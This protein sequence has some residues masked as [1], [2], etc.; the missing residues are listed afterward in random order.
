MRVLMVSKAVLRGPYQRKLEE[1]AR[2]GVELRVVAPPH[3]DEAGQRLSL[4]RV[5]VEGYEL[6]VEPMA[7]NGRFHLHFYPG[8]DRRLRE[9]QPDLVHLDEEP[10]NLATFHG[11][12]EAHRLGRPFLFFA[13]QNLHRRYP[14]PFSA[15]ERWVLGRAVRAIA[16]TREAEAVLRRKGF[17]RPI[18]AIPQFGVDERLFAP[19]PEPEGPFTIG[20]AG[21]LVP[22]KGMETLV[23]AA[24]GLPGEWRLR[25]VGSGAEAPRL[26]GLAGSLDVADRLSLEPPLGA[27]AMPGFY[28]HIHVLVLPS[29]TRPNWKEQFGRVLVEAM[30]S[31]RPV[32]GSESGEIPHTIGPA[33]LLFPEG[34]AEALRQQLL[35]LRS[36]AGL[37]TR[38]AQAGRERV[39]E[40]FTQAEVARRTVQAYREALG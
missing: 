13:W 22:E 34:D 1:I 12:R 17:A 29:L 4:E 33:G 32:V 39:L 15:M 7:F 24:S 27:S 6:I 35:R 11:A 10:Y 19:S 26:A 9:F 14:W 25:L 3:W 28:R 18:D 2:A 20:Y 36:D 30:S 37:R 38:L 8:L 16:G 31:G 40:R 5:H 21:R 23:R